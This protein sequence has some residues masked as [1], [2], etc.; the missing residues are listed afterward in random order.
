MRVSLGTCVLSIGYPII[1]LWL[2]GRSIQYSCGLW[3]VASA[4]LWRLSEIIGG[5]RQQHIYHRQHRFVA[6]VIVLTRTDTEPTKKKCIQLMQLRC[7]CNCS[8]VQRSIGEHKSA[9]SRN[10]P[11]GTWMPQHILSDC[12]SNLNVGG[13]GRFGLIIITISAV[14]GSLIKRQLPQRESELNVIGRC[15]HSLFNWAAVLLRGNSH[16]WSFQT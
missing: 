11:T 1:W 16:R 15:C 3:W 7:C 2:C 13:S 14:C 6:C 4:T 10:A 8:R 12:R 9:A 5:H